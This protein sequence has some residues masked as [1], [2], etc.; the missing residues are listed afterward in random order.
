[1][2][3]LLNLFLILLICITDP[4]I[5]DYPS[6]DICSQPGYF[7]HNGVCFKVYDKMDQ[8]KNFAD[9][10]AQCEKDTGNLATV[11]DGFFEAFMETLLFYYKIRDAWIG[12][13]QDVS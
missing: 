2:V 3:F 6:G 13:L 11:T 1:M 5:P 8:R 10:Q 12:L 9:A 4:A 7:R